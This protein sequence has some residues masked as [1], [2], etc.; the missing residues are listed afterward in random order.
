LRKPDSSKPGVEFQM[1]K[2]GVKPMWED[3]FNKRGGK[4]SFKLKKDYTTIIW[5]EIVIKILNRF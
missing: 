4:F 2:E 5:E 3:E 1:F